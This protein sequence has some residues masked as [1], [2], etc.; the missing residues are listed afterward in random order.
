[1]TR[2]TLIKIIIVIGALV[3]I[4]IKSGVFAPKDEI[5][6]LQNNYALC[7]KPNDEHFAIHRIL[8]VNEDGGQN[9][10]LEVEP[11]VVS[12]PIFD[13]TFETI[14]C[15][16]INDS[17]NWVVLTA[18]GEKYLFD[19]SHGKLQLDGNSFTQYSQDN[20]GGSCF[21]TQVGIYPLSETPG[22][23]TKVEKYYRTGTGND[24][25][26][27]R[28]NGKWGVYNRVVKEHGAYTTPEYLYTQILPAQF[29]KIRLVRGD[30]AFHYVAYK[31]GEWQ[32]FDARGRKR[33][34]CTST[35]GNQHQMNVKSSTGRGEGIITDTYISNIIKIPTNSNNQYNSYLRT[36]CT[37]SGDEEAGIIKL[38]NHPDK[39]Q[40][41]F[42]AWNGDWSIFDFDWDNCRDGFDCNFPSELS[43]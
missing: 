29:D 37:Y 39:Y 36:Q 5:V 1:M 28:K 42:A 19:C 16:D 35:S 23:P 14:T 6:M 18:A 3:F 26:I 11:I 21:I 32:L 9:R 38:D 7:K 2:D 30:G 40:R 31:N 15:P 27:Y 10:S 24:T 13:D 8:S 41:F 4:L 25:F 43:L 22:L 20:I 34:M 33:E 17:K 12:E